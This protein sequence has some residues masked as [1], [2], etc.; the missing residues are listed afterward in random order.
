M[1]IAFEEFQAEN[2]R[3]GSLTLMPSLSSFGR[4]FQCQVSELRI[5]I[6]SR[7]DMSNCDICLK[8]YAQL[9]SVSLTKQG[10]AVVIEE[11][12]RHKRFVRGVREMYYKRI[13]M[14]IDNPDTHASLIIG[15]R[16]SNIE[17]FLPFV[18]V[19]GMDQSST[20]VPF[21][22][23]ESHD[24]NGQKSTRLVQR[25][26]GALLH[27][28]AKLLYVV[29]PDVP[30]GANQVITILQDVLT[31]IRPSVRTL[32]IQID[33]SNG[34]FP[35]KPTFILTLNQR[36]GTPLCLPFVTTLFKAGAFL[37]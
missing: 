25:V 23:H 18:C 6:R 11:M 29:N 21:S 17:K 10:R 9:R 16:C 14:A 2:S 3:D 30:K 15:D 5:S 20:N 13:Q 33:G 4:A 37:K 7:K 12:V 26:H 22:S 1:K 27:G 32:S 35:V 28:I 34:T 8:L 31:R 36:I 19:D 24:Q